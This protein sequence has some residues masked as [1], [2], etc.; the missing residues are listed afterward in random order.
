MNP[1]MRWTHQYVAN[2]NVFRDCLKLFPP[3]TGSRKLSGRVVVVVVLLVALCSSSF[4]VVR[5]CTSWLTW[6]N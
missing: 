5:S 4:V 6:V 2:R 3:I 1:L